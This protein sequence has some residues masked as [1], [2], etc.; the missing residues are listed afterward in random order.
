VC[1]C[2][3]M[4]VHVCVFVCMCELAHLKAMERE[5]GLKHELRRT[6]DIGQ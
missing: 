3:C 5:P 4:C 1:T 2:V 6:P